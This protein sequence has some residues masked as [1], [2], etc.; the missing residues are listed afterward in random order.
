MSRSSASRYI[1]DD[2]YPDD[3][4]I[5]GFRNVGFYGNLKRLTAPKKLHRTKFKL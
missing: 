4:G 5:D 2:Q 1:R 3:E